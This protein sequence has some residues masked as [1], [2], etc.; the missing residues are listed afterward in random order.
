MG[1][2]R[3]ARA[4]AIEVA[5]QRGKDTG[6]LVICLN[7]QEMHWCCAILDFDR[8][9]RVEFDPLQ[10]GQVYAF[11]L[12]FCEEYIQ[13]RIPIEYAGLKLEKFKDFKQQDGYNCGL[14]TAEFVEHYV[15][16]TLRLM[17]GDGDNVRERQRA[18]HRRLVYLSRI[19]SISTLLSDDA[20]DQGKDEA[21]GIDEVEIISIPAAGNDVMDEVKRSDREEN[22]YSKKRK[23]RRGPRKTK[24]TIETEDEDTPLPGSRKKTIRQ[25]V[26]SSEAS[27]SLESPS[28]Q[29]PPSPTRVFS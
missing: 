17:R 29:P 3:Q 27:S 26:Y 22:P 5:L 11:L 25:I 8:K 13:P 15:M 19:W 1:V 28:P 10:I 14:Y 18:Q 6:M 16:D 9:K 21:E 20:E 4:N 7:F 12:N 2:S 24:S 23:R